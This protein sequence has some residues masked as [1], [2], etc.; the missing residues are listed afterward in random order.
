MKISKIIFEEL[1]KKS[2]IL[3]GTTNLGYFYTIYLLY[4]YRMVYNN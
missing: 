2:S 1:Q 3:I 4:L